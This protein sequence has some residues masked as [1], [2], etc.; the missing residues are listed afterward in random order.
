LPPVSITEEQ[1]ARDLTAAMK[2]RD[3]QRLEVLRGVV[4]AAKLL[5]VERRVSSLEEA[6]L[7]QVL[8]KELRKREEAEEF[9]AKA[10][11]TDLVV[12]NRAER[13]ILEGYVPA[14]LGEADLERAI[15]ESLAGGTPRQLGPVMS[16]LRE[17]YAGRYDGKTASELARR[18]LAEP[19][20]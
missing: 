16:A 4:A 19:V 18:I 17:R 12:Q 3:S 6:D 13:S 10:G 11:R 20:T 1:L 7:V 9:A 14:L 2:A 15:R 5:K 8:R